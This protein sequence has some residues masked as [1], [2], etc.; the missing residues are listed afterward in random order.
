MNELRLTLLRHYGKLSMT[1]EKLGV[2]P[3]SVTTWL[4]S[5]PRNMLKHLPE[6]H[7]QTGIS[8]ADWITMVLERER[9]I[10]NG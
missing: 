5:S 7:A 1:A 9:E 6:L 4:E 10:H 2:Q 3:A 8:Y